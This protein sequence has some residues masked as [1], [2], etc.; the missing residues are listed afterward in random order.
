[1]KESFF[2]AVYDPF[3]W[4][5]ERRGMRARRADLLREARGRVLEIGAGTG[6][7]VPHYTSEV[8]EL[9]LTE[10]VAPMYERLRGRAAGRTGVVVRQATGEELP[11]PDD[12]V[13]TVV[14]TLVLCTVPD[15]EAVLDEIAR[16]LR[17]GGVFLFCEHVLAQDTKAA[18]GQRR[19]APHWAKFAGGCHTDRDTATALA[20]RF[21][22]KRMQDERWRGMPSWVRPLITGVAVA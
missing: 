14:S 3:L 18:R 1:M 19:I 6:L 9:I 20:G 7:N 5:G 22:I 17:P 15:V 4:L 12:S 21:E 13:D 10:P 8:S 16:V 11:V 2:A